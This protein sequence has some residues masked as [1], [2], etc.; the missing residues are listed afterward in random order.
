MIFLE[1]SLSLSLSFCLLL[2]LFFFHFSWLGLALLGLT[3]R[4]VSVSKSCK[5][6][7]VL[8]SGCSALPSRVFIFLGFWPFFLGFGPS[9]FLGVGPLLWC[10]PFLLWRIGPFLTLEEVN[11]GI[12]REPLTPKVFFEILFLN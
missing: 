10:S 9:F 7:L 3:W 2:F 1:F 6:D 11:C 8:P 4:S 12:T 5:I